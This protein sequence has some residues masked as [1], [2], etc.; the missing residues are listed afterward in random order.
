MSLFFC[1]F[2]LFKNISFYG[3]R[4]KLCFCVMDIIGFVR[5]VEEDVERERKLEML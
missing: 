2:F 3:I 4:F 5:G 1:G